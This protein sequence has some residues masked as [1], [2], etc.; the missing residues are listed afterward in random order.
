VTWGV[1]AF[2]WFSTCSLGLPGSINITYLFLIT[3]REKS[4]L[5]SDRGPGTQ[6]SNHG[7]A[8]TQPLLLY[9]KII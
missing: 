4:G 7:R 6:I 3:L 2:P 5:S 9:R 8:S 1:K